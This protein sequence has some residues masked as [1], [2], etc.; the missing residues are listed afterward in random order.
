MPD[1]I[2]NTI[3]YIVNNPKDF[4]NIC[5]WMITAFLAIITYRNAKKTLFNPIRSEMVKYQM[6]VIT[7]FI[8]DHTSKGQDF[9]YSIDYHNLLKINYETDYLF[10]FLTDEYEFGNHQFDAFDNDRLNF[11]KENMGGLFELNAEGSQLKFQLVSGD[12]DSAKQ[13]IQTSFIKDK[14]ALHVNLGLQR[15]YLTKRFH[16]F[17]TDLLNL[18]SNPFIPK[19][20]KNNIDDIISNILRNLVILQHLLSDHISKQTD[21]KY[22]TIYAQFTTG[23]NDHRD[24]L[25]RLRVEIAKF[26]KVNI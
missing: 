6:K 8:D 16:T 22:Q 25:E 24:D 1:F 19:K 10:S 7:E 26:F 4:V 5:F 2:D 9:D 3:E 11:C 13:Y 21:A 23:K 17:Y 18:K 12:F 15:L 20:I 14:E